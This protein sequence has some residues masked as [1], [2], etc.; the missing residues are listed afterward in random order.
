MNLFTIPASRPFL[1]TLALTLLNET[2][3]DPLRLSK[4][5]ILLP[6]R[7]A[8]RALQDIFLD[9]TPKALFLPRLWPLGEVDAEEVALSSLPGNDL[10]TSLPPVMNNSRRQMLLTSLI[11]KFTH[12]WRHAEATPLE[13]SQA[14]E[15]ALKLMRLLDQVETE[16]ISL[17]KI[18]TIVPHDYAN[19]WQITIDFLK[20]I[21][22][23]WPEI[24]KEEGTLSSATYRRLLMEAQ[25]IEWERTPPNFPIIAAGS[26]GTIA[27][28]FNLL[29]VIAHLPQGRVII[30]AFD[31]HIQNPDGLLQTHP[32]YAAYQLLHKF[33]GTVQDVR[34]WDEPNPLPYEDFLYDMFRE[35]SKF[36]LPL[37]QSPVSHIDLLECQS[38][39]E[40]AETIALAMREVYETPY[41]TALLVTSD[42]SL[43]RRVGAELKRWGLEVNDSAGVPFAQT[44]TGSFLRITG[45]WCVS[46]FSLVVL[47]S[48]LKHPFCHGPQGREKIVLLTRL[49]EKHVLRKNRPILSIAELK[50]RISHI[51]PPESVSL[52]DWEALKHF[53]EDICFY[54]QE[55]HHAST[56][57]HLS[58]KELI[59]VH[60]DFL[61]YLRGE[62]L[63]SQG[64]FD[65]DQ[66]D[67]KMG[68]EFWD[69]LEQTS[70]DLILPAGREYGLF[71]EAI[72]SPLVTRCA[73]TATP[74]LDIL[75]VIEGRLLTADMV[76]LGG[77]NEG[78]WPP[79]PEPDP[80]F[81]RS[82][83]TE[84][85]L[86]L[87]EREIGRTAHDFLQ[88]L[89]A[90]RVL[91]TRSLRKDGA[92][93]VSSRFL[94]RLQTFLQKKRLKLSY[95]SHLHEWHRQLKRHKYSQ[96]NL[97]SS[98]PAPCPPISAR[99]QTFSVTDVGLWM[100]DPYALY[101]KRILGLKPL[102]DL[103]RTPSAIEFGILI[104]EVLQRWLLS[105]KDQNLDLWEQGILLGK[106]SFDYYFGNSVE[107]PFWWARFLR[108]LNWFLTTEISLNLLEIWTEISGSASFY[109]EQGLY[110]LKAKAD[111]IQLN[112]DHTL[113]IIDYKTGQLPS[114]KSIKW[115]Y[116]PQLP[117]EAA[118]LLQGQFEKVP[119]QKEIAAL[120]FWHLSGK[121][122]P[123]EIYI[124]KE[125][126]QDLADSAW[127]GFQSLVKTFENP[128]T[129][130][131]SKPHGYDG[132]SYDD[133][134]H[135]ARVK[136]WAS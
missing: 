112:Q 24:L 71:L 30:P 104:H 85:G 133:Y 44:L 45:S 54:A 87:P 83:R 10:I 57:P 99:P 106:R 129:C 25:A 90:P 119:T 134:D 109:T 12:E 20:I 111:R 39:Q 67:G 125:S 127:Q 73:W 49:L 128:L 102:M 23:Y 95:P 9:L 115:G 98:P 11:L 97:L 114:L 41:K 96:E 50:D 79:D 1:K 118:I 47:L 93:T 77:M 4:Y 53:V 62:L 59:K 65:V 68:Q 110:T 80:W 84:L 51:T 6:T 91:L 17:D 101:A 21:S 105:F 116:S 64:L 72:M 13:S 94:S 103:N 37:S 120:S 2:R 63:E 15:L 88:H 3:H 5:L 16:G 86:P 46:E 121:E 70:H 55:F 29:Q 100:K 132:N 38:I 43:A 22:A 42:R 89:M 123:G 26:L 36:S 113:E 48:T 33:K 122:P 28:T 31:P 61:C 82:M 75:G 19:H 126:P 56:V 7:R 40:E 81:S 34:P 108:I 27:P 69:S 92:P 66:E 124:L 18:Q 131:R 136:E 78:T 32:Q 14:A 52:E 74:R 76:I 8:C 60:K 58:L 117:L 135:L 130:Y 35:E 107:R